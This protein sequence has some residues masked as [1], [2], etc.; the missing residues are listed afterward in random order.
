M[1]DVVYMVRGKTRE[2]CERELDW[3]CKHRGAQPTM[4]PTDAL[5]PGWVA[6][7]VPRPPARVEREPGQ[8]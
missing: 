6:R 8:Q 7:A 3:L 4:L 2:L 5:P 1:D